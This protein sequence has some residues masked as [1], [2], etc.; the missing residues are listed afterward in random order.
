MAAVRVYVRA[1]ACVRACVSACVRAYVR[2][3]VRVCAHVPHRPAKPKKQDIVNSIF[4]TLAQFDFRFEV[5][6][7]RRSKLFYVTSN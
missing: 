6:R 3:Y 1:C 4:L 7:W 2:T 5:K